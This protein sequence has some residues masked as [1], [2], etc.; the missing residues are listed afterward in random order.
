MQRSTDHRVPSSN[1]YISS[2]TPPP[3][4]Y[5]I[6]WNKA[7]ITRQKTRTYAKTVFPRNGKNALPI[8]PQQYGCLNKTQMTMPIVMLTH[9]RESHGIPPL[10]KELQLT[11]DC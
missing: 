8:K 1:E 4:V 7:Q 5:G 3:K 6:L 2:T 11:N 9:K 10:D